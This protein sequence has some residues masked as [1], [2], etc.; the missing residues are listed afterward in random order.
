MAFAPPPYKIELQDTPFSDAFTTIQ[1]GRRIFSKQSGIL[2]DLGTGVQF[3]GDPLCF[4]IGNLVG[5]ASRFPGVVYHKDRSGS[6]GRTLE[7]AL[8]GAIG[9]AVERYCMRFYWEDQLIVG[10]YKELSGEYELVHPDIIRLHS[11]AQLDAAKP[12]TFG[13]YHKFL[14]SETTR[15]AWTWSYSLTHERWKL[16]PANMVY[17]PYRPRENEQHTGWNSST[18]LAAGNTMEEAIL[19]GIC[20]WVERDAFVI[21]WLNRMIP[22]E[23]EVDNSELGAWIT[24]SFHIGRQRQMKLRIFDITLDIAIPSVL[25]WMER[26]ME[27]GP[28]TFV[29][30]ASRLSPRGA[31]EKALIELAQC[32]PCCRVNLWKEAD[33]QPREDFSDIVNF[34]RHSIFYQKRRDLV[35]TAFQFCRQVDRKVKLSAWTDHATGRPLDDIRY[36]VN[37]LAR[38]GYEVLVTDLTTDDISQIGMKAV[39]VVVP[40][41]QNLHG[42]HNWPCLGVDRVYEIP[43]KLGWERF[44][45]REEAGLNP[46]PH[47]FP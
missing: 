30:A 3:A 44:G 39:R 25:V 24:E 11:Q 6:A 16:V 32:V 9:E 40:G 33:W 5:D 18:G 22:R 2:R 4:N 19:G 35:D 17:L 21:C 15:A 28:A 47:P 42:N 27:W 43:R 14:F 37:E 31:I 38:H 12:E 26:P 10:S 13:K 46:Y 45:W 36:T 7:R 29:G 34:D 1:K 20:E 23:I 8:A 41:L